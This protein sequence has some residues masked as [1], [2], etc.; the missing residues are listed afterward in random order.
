MDKIEIPSD[1]PLHEIDVAALVKREAESIVGRRLRSR[2]PDFCPKC[3]K[4]LGIR[5]VLD[6][7]AIEQWMREPTKRPEADESTATAYCGVHGDI[8]TVWGATNQPI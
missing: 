5:Q 2:L 3:S 8:V 4:P 6:M 7:D 1:H